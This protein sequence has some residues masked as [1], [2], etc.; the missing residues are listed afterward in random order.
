MATQR[1][2]LTYRDYEALPNDGR[3][4]EILDGALAVTPAPNPY[5]QDVLANLHELVR[6][7]V[8]SRA[9]GRVF[10]APVDVIL[11]DTTVVQPD[12]VYLDSERAQRVS[13]RGIEG[14]PT[15]VV[16]VLSPSTAAI[17]R[18]DKLRIYARYGVP[19]YWIV[20]I[21]ARVIDVHELADGAYR[22]IARAAGSRRVFLPPFPDL[23]LVPDSLWP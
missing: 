9:L 19:Y 5:H 10:F 1:G 13:G 2:T 8:R 6:H 23:A 15:L 16:E 4:H 17:D 7:H 14:P 18:G 21:D 20:D 3:H 22:L 11:S 12:L